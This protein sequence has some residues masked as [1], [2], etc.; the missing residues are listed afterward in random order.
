MSRIS[1][2]VFGLLLIGAVAVL[3]FAT[4]ASAQCSG[5]FLSG[6]V[7][8]NSAAGSGFA[9]STTVTA[10]FDRIYGATQNQVIYRGASGWTGLP[11]ANNGVWATNGSGVPAIVTTLPSGLV[12]PSPGLTGVPT[13]PT[14]SAGTNTTQI[15]TT[16]FVGATTREKLSTARTYFVR[17]DGSDSNTCL[18][19]TSGGACL[20]VQ[21]AVNK[22]YLL[23]TAGFTVTL[24][25]AA[26][27]YTGATT[28]SGPMVGGGL[29]FLHGDS[30]TPTNVVLTAI[31]TTLTINSQPNTT[32]D[33][34]KFTATGNCLIVN[35]RSSVT[36]QSYNMGGCSDRSIEVSA[37]AGLTSIGNYTISG[38]GSIF[39]HVIQNSKYVSDSSVA[40]I[41]GTPNF[42]TFF[43]G[44]SENSSSNFATTWSGSATGGQIFIHQGSIV[45]G[46]AG[47][48][49]FAYFPGSLAF[50]NFTGASTYNDVFN[51]IQARTQVL[52]GTPTAGTVQMYADSTANT[53]QATNASGTN[54]TMVFPDA[55]ASNNFLTGITAAGLVTK[56]QPGISNI[57]GLGT[58]VATAL[59]VNVGSAGSFVVNG[60]AFGTPSSGVLTNATGLPISTGVAGLGTNVATALAVAV[61]TD[62]AFV[63]KGGAL[64]SPSSGNLTNATYNGAIPGQ[65]L[66]VASGVNFNSANTD[67]A[68][69]V[70]LPTGYTRYII[71]SF[72]IV[73]ASASL[74]T[75]TVGVFTATGG[76]GTAVVTSGSA[77][78]VSTASDNTN[79]NSQILVPV[80]GN[81]QSYAVA[82][83][84][85]LYFR[86]Q[87]PQGS[88][89][90]ASVELII[91]P[92]P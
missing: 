62:G 11:S 29:L 10:L 34:F 71:N 84:P 83:I 32:V 16:A 27:T 12:I 24:S 44:T 14:A 86:V 90:T 36:L 15:A 59:A 82:T 20:T 45:E 8:A 67:T 28:I 43:F 35:N 6:N 52:P 55:G 46:P 49:P 17:T 22:A 79:N 23:D 88:A 58:S 91:V 42:S 77:V 51:L 69:N 4:P 72:R 7:C 60:G 78:S 89:A 53:F 87:N 18:A 75:S 21:G 81:S 48:S 61:G 39:L 40:T 38:G 74:T 64:G 80:N 92:V 66:Y 25:V 56:A 63:V 85:T 57:S 33:G 73:V 37:F 70:T 47:V 41:T 68:F 5:S 76:G 1:R 26:G 3:S 13:A 19:N 2:F 54:S 50:N 65:L 30:S 31:G 9:V